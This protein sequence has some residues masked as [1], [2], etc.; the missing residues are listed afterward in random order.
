MLRVGGV[1]AL[2]ERLVEAVEVKFRNAPGQVVVGIGER[3]SDLADLYSSYEQ[4]RRATRVA[5]IVPAFSPVAVWSALGIY[6]ALVQFPLEHLR[7]NLLHPGLLALLKD[8]TQNELVGTLER[9]LDLAGSAK[10]TAADLHLHRATLYYRLRRI[11]QIVGVDLEDGND[12]L[13]LHLSLKLARLAGIIA[14]VGASEPARSQ[15]GH[16]LNGARKASASRAREAAT[17]AGRP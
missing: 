4:A 5:Q 6:R 17:G 13:A 8:G 14:E 2:A 7:A 16:P 3:Q 11:E 15:N 1:E 9:F 12:R 10:R